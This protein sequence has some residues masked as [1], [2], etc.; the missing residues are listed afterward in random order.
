MK[1]TEFILS[2]G[3]L[4]TLI[5]ETA[6]EALLDELQLTPKPGLVDMLNSGCHFDL[7]VDL[8]SASAQSLY[9]AFH[10]M[11]LA[12]Q[13]K[14]A[15]QALR[16]QLAAIGRYGE[17]QMLDVTGNINTHKGAI[18]CV[19]LLTA[20]AAIHTRNA[21][22]FT[23]QDLLAT[24]GRIAAFEDRFVPKKAT[25]GDQVRNQYR[26]I[27]AREEAMT[28]FPTIRD[29][30]IPAWEKYAGEPEYIRQ[31]NVLLSLMAVVDDTCI[32]H[33]TNMY[34]LKMI[35]KKS[36]AIMESGGISAEDNWK[37]YQELDKFITNHWVSPGGS[38]DLLAATIFIHKI[39]THF[40]IN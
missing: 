13:D 26:V 9:G 36:R 10:H 25:N 19:G 22:S 27:S 38:A 29:T 5:A 34:V 2:E 8:M 15:S 6:V 23:V 28:G 14:D 11:A 35:Q 39:T 1:S 37:H 7:N 30:A 20:A 21:D 40:K 31:L 12:A 24:A 18:W 3:T 32:I 16:E 17:Q 4:S 33:R